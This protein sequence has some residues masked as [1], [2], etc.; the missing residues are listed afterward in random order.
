MARIGVEG[1]TVGKSGKKNKT[2]KKQRND[3]K[4]RIR[5]CPKCA[6]IK[7]KDLK[8]VL[9]SGSFKTG[10]IGTCVKKHPELNNKA[11]AKVDGELVVCDSK[12]KLVK[13][14]AKAQG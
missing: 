8:D 7:G 14:L 2:D 5:I 12:K 3:A 1:G 9:P 11:F 10:C 4:P 13:K 6:H